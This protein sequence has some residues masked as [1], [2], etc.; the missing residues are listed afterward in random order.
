MS[1]NHH[2][3]AR[4]NEEQGFSSQ[5]HARSSG[6]LHLLRRSH[7]LKRATVTLMLSAALLHAQDAPRPN[8][9]LPLPTDAPPAAPALAPAPAPESQGTSATAMQL[10]TSRLV[11]KGVLGKDEA[12][13]LVKLAEA[14]IANAVAKAQTQRTPADPNAVR[15]TYVPEIVKNQL[16][17]EIKQ[18]LSSDQEWIVKKLKGAGTFPDWVSRWEPFGD[19]RVRYEYDSYPVGNDNF[20]SFPNFNAINTGAPYDVAGTLFS[21]Q[22]NTDQ[23]RQRMRLRMRLGTDIHLGEGFTAGVRVGTG[24]TN[25]PVSGNQSLGAANQGPVSYTHLTLPSNRTVEYSGVVRPLNKITLIVS[26]VLVERRLDHNMRSR[27]VS[28]RSSLLH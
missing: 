9:L 5:R 18:E 7:T 25:S 13:E 19:V 8:P 28:S 11:E 24:E 15:V 2:D 1:S 6:L 26:V 27:T 16:R 20:G 14:D 3:Q 4:A 22:Y 17:E 21:P 23:D 10:L 12:T